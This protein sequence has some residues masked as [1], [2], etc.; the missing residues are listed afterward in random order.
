MATHLFQHSGQFVKV[1]IGE[2]LGLPQVQDHTCRTGLGGKVVQVPGEIKE[3]M[4]DK[5]YGEFG[6]NMQYKNLNSHTLSALT[7]L[8]IRFSYGT[9]KA[10]KFI[11]EN[12]QQILSY[13]NRLGGQDISLVRP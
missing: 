5:R 3:T 13:D 12:Q 10:V 7:F 1:S 11:I 2:V 9:L 6:H 8:E 4:V